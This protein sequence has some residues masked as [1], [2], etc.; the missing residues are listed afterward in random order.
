MTEKTWWLAYDDGC[1][2]P[3]RLEAVL[4][5]GTAKVTPLDPAPD[6][7]VTRGVSIARVYDANLMR[8]DGR[9]SRIV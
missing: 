8:P 5:M 9:P 2:W 6:A 4:P 7:G 3:C 1:V